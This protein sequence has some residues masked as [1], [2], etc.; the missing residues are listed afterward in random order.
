V[1]TAEIVAGS[2][3]QIVTKYLQKMESCHETWDFTTS[4]SRTPGASLLGIERYPSLL[5]GALQEA[6]ALVGP[7]KDHVLTRQ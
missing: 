6:T 5:L 3:K 2:C 4:A 7:F 1:F